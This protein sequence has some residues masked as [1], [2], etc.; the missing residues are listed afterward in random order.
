MDMKNFKDLYSNVPPSKQERQ[1]DKISPVS[2]E[3]IDKTVEHLAK[4]PIF[5]PKVK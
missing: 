5:T 3:L 4:E 2:P 1:Y